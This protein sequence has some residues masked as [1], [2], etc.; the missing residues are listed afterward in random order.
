VDAQLAGLGA[1]QV[2]A[3]ANV[4]AKIKQLVELESLLSHG[5]FFDVDLQFL[6]ALLDVRKPRFAHQPDRH[7][8]SSNADVHSRGIEFLRRLPGIIGKNLFDA[9]RVLVFRAVDRLP[10]RLNLLQ[11]LA[12]QFVDVLVQ[13]Q[14]E[15]SIPRNEGRL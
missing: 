1:E 9:V 14:R 12:A 13:C 10:E 3:R 7:N 4:I 2:A 15:S 5:I 11:F 6:A 8:A